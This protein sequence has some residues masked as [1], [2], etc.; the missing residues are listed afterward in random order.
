[1][2]LMDY[3]MQNMQ[4]KALG[5]IPSAISF[6]PIHCANDEET[7]GG[8]ACSSYT[9]DDTSVTS[10]ETEEEDD[11]LFGSTYTPDDTSVEMEEEDDLLGL[12]LLLDD[13]DE[14]NI[15]EMEAETR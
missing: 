5:E 1:M 13:D 7:R 11:D 2:H 12:D 10:V 8:D 15:D 4:L 9:Q 3:K 6:T 14:Y